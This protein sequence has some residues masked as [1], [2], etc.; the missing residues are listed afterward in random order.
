MSRPRIRIRHRPK[1]LRKES[2]R[3]PIHGSSERGDGRDSGRY[4]ECWHCGFICDAERDFLGG[5]E[6]SARVTPVSY[7]QVGEDTTTAA[8]HCQGAL[9]STSPTVDQTACEAAGG[10]WS[11]VR[12]KPEVESGCPFCGTPNWRGDYP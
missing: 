5:P 7:N 6:D 1:K 3:I 11:R 10:T 8:Y 12:Y 9:A 4:F 2:K